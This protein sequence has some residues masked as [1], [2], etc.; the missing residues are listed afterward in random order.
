MGQENKVEPE[1]NLQTIEGLSDAHAYVFNRQKTGDIDP[2]TADSM[3]TTLKG[4][5][6]LQGKL[7]IEA[8]KLYILSQTKHIQIP[9]ELLPTMHSDSDN[10]KIEAK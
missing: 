3:N 2:K 1:F 5:L 4:L 6:Y 10:N 7:K 8:A 9:P